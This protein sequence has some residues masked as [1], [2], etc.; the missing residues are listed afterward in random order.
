MSPNDSMER[1]QPF[2]IT[3]RG[4]AAGVMLSLDAN[5]RG[6]HERQLLLFLARRER[7]IG[8]DPVVKAP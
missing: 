1:K 3:Q 2:I 8:A 4:S 5:E 7:G 6:E